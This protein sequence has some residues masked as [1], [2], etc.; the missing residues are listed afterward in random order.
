[1]GLFNFFK[2]T[3]SSQSTYESLTV[4]DKLFN[5]AK[6]GI[7]EM[8]R[9]YKDLSDKGKFEVI[10]FN[11]SIGIWFYN[12]RNPNTPLNNAKYAM[13]ILDQARIYNIRRNEDDLMNFIGS[14]LGF[15]ANEYNQLSDAENIPGKVYSNFFV[16]P[17]SNNPE[18]S[19]DLVEIF[20]FKTALG[21][22]I[23]KVK[24]SIYNI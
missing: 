2:S 23:N 1:M 24:Q 18:P 5:I 4:E 16:N 13:K 15:Y 17:L 8:K 14:R 20:Q 22:M 21:T 3:N 11:S 7:I 10:L 19:F 12:N 6:D 9:S